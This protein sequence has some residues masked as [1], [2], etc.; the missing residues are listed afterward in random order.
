MPQRAN[1]C[2]ALLDWYAEVV[3][4]GSTRS[5]VFTFFTYLSGDAFQ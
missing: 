3:S 1:L 2:F 5:A 4:S